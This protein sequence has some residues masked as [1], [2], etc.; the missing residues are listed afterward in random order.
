MIS[1]GKRSAFAACLLALPFALASCG[2]RLGDAHCLAG[3]DGAGVPAVHREA[4]P[5]T[6]PTVRELREAKAASMQEWDALMNGGLPLYRGDGSSSNINSVRFGASPGALTLDCYASPRLNFADGEPHALT[7]VVYHLSDRAA[8]DQLARHEEGIRKLLEGEYF[9]DSVVGVRRHDIQPGARVRLL[10][11]R[12]EGGRYVAL[13]AG[14]GRLHARTSVH[15]AEYRLYRWNAAG[16]SVFSRDKA[17]YSPY[18]MHLRA[19]LDEEEMRV[20][21]RD[22]TLE[23]M[24]AVTKVERA[25]AFARLMPSTRSEAGSF[26]ESLSF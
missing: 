11:D 19:L 25:Q 8:F 15:V 18:P 1:Q 24:R 12:R 9:D 17:M 23:R 22:A 21:D 7:L 26:A 10:E 13:V 4:S 14:Y 6:R 5:Q 2:A 16:E 20:D 3:T